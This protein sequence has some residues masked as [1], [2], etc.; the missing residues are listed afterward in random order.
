MSVYWL[1]VQDHVH[2]DNHK[3]VLHIFVS[4]FV[5]MLLY[6]IGRMTD[7]FVRKKQEVVT[8][9]MSANYQIKY[10]LTQYVSR[11]FPL[12]YSVYKEDTAA[13]HSTQV[14]IWWATVRSKD[15]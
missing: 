3:V 2:K 1:L 5:A 4:Q 12:L 13:P 14:G 6:H 15:D 10:L 7:L 8:L 11:M 9:E